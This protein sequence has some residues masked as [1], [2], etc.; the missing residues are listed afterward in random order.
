MGKLPGLKRVEGPELKLR[1]GEG[2]QKM[3]ETRY[4]SPGF[5]DYLTGGSALNDGIWALLVPWQ[6]IV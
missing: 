3:L 5:M 6:F 2:L 1:A 4:A